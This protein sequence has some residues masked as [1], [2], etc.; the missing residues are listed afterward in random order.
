MQT[1]TTTSPE[2]TFDLGR[3]MAESIQ[4]KTV[5][6][7]EGDLG[8]GKTTFAKGVAA[9]LE[10]DPRDVISPTFT[11]MADYEGRMKL[12]H[13]DLYRIDHPQ[14]VFD[15]LGLG[16]V[17]NEEAVAI[18]EWAEKLEDF[19]V[20]AGYWIRFQWIDEA[21]REITIEP[22]GDATLPGGG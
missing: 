10:I 21:T 9:G 17:M 2:A 8:S 14:D 4:S 5:F 19:P 12:Y 20:E 11:L 22:I 1:V 3:Q 18:I 6:L 15:H 16:D 13:V 7:L